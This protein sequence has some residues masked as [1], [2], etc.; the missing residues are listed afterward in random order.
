MFLRDEAHKSYPTEFSPVHVFSPSPVSWV[1]EVRPSSRK[2]PLR[3]DL[4]EPLFAQAGKRSSQEARQ[5]RLPQGKRGFTVPGG[6]GYQ[7]V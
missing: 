2:Q 3:K 4:Q 7:N 1:P 5:A 6:A